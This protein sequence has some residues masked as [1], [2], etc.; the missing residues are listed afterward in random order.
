MNP[1]FKVLVKIAHTL[2]IDLPEILRFE[3][4]ISES[5]ELEKRIQ[6]ILKDLSADKLQNVL[7][8][9]RVLYPVR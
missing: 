1:S 2:D 6:M 9:L 7:T 5:K 8:L 4:E 3:Q